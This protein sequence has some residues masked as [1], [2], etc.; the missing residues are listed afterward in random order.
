MKSISIFVCAVASI[1]AAQNLHLKAKKSAGQKNLEY[2]FL[3]PMGSA[4]IMSFCVMHLCWEINVFNYLFVFHYDG[5]V[6]G[7][8]TIHSG[9]KLYV[10]GK[11][12]PCFC[13]CLQSQ[14]S[15]FAKP[16]FRRSNRFSL[17]WF[18]E[19]HN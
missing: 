19:G 1:P 18:L 17:Q 10:F 5:E 8:A 15:F 16:L 12:T 6:E 11:N 7:H 4:E 9:G 13:G 14:Q 2:C 3:S